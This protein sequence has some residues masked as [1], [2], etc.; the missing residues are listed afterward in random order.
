MAPKGPAGVTINV[1]II[2]SVSQYVTSNN[3]QFYWI[4]SNGTCVNGVYSLGKCS[5]FS[6][7]HTPEIPYT[8]IITGFTGPKC[9][10]PYV[11]PI[12]SPIS[13]IQIRETK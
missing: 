10:I 5:C 8:E 1:T 4:G 13:N 6:G 3:T 7:I 11:S 12:I 2:D 9:E